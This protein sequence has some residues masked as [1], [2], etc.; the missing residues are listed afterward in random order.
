MNMRDKINNVIRIPTSL[1]GK[2][3]RYWLEFLRPFH[4][5]SDR[6]V[7]IATSLL[8]N[9]YELSK[10]I[11]DDEILDRVLLSEDTRKKIM[12]ECNI[13]PS[14]L[15]VIMTRLRKSKVI[16]DNRINPKFIPNIVEGRDSFSLLLHFDLNNDV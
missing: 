1:N 2:F 5:L 12:A 6:E 3:F 10:V 7:Q 9:R 8:R 15:Q 13:A 14:H 16:V 4:N 11:T